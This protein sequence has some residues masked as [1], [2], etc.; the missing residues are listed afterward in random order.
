MSVVYSE[1]RDVAGLVALI[2][3]DKKPTDDR[4]VDNDR[5]AVKCQAQNCNPIVVSCIGC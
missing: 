4:K 3:H 1:L 2:A 5:S